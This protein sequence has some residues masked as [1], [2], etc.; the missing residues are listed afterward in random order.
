MIFIDILS[1]TIS[2]NEIA[3][4]D[5]ACFP[6]RKT[7]ANELK[8]GNKAQ[9]KSLSNDYT[10]DELKYVKPTYIEV[11]KRLNED[12]LKGDYIFYPKFDTLVSEIHRQLI[13][14][15][16]TLEKKCRFFISRDISLNAMSSIFNSYVINLGS[17]H[18]LRSK[19][20]LAALIAHEEAHNSLKHTITS[21]KNEFKI[22]KDL[23]KSSVRDIKKS[24]Y[25]RGSKATDQF[26]SLL[27]SKGRLE[28]QQEFEA[29]SLGYILYRNAGYT[30]EQYLSAFKLTMEYDTVKT[31]DL[32]I[33]I[34]KKVF[35]LPEQPF[36]NEWMKQEDF[37]Q[38]D[39]SKFKEKFDKDLIK[40]HP[41]TDE[42]IEKLKRIF[43]ELAVT[44]L[45]DNVKSDSDFR[46]LRNTA[47][48]EIFQ[49]LD[50]GEDYGFGVYICLV[51]L[52]NSALNTEEETKYYKHW[53]GKYFTKIHKARKEYT[54]NRYLDKVDPKDHP[55]DYQ[56]YLNFMWNLNVAELETIAKHYSI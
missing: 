4:L 9:L 22:E 26:K 8:N 35:D 39:Y 33:E 28:R 21:L 56:I 24:K 53:L 2:G 34:Y 50:I 14:S 3:P 5:T 1:V 55:K 16:S 6:Q 23:A 15:N 45:I 47:F 10:A 52:A 17:F 32:D 38:Y 44:S 12:I 20:E 13:Y 11:Q 48:Y 40:S 36:K 31:E 43:P 46:A 29:D 37:S 41:E 19:D 25:S 42:R 54:L 18:F 27:Y 7:F 30:P 49:S 51:R